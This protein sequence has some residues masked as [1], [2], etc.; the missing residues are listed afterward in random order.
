MTLSQ[1]VNS[2]NFRFFIRYLAAHSVYRVIGVSTSVSS[3]LSL[4]PIS[5][6]LTKLSQGQSFI[7]L[8]E[9]SHGNI[10]IVLS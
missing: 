6:I 10:F 7:I 9:L 3:Q 4:R 1:T 5:I 8:S 2:K